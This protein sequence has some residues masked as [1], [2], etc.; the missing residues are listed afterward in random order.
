MKTDIMETEPN[1]LVLPIDKKNL[2]TSSY[3][4]TVDYLI[5][6]I[7]E[8]KIILE[9]P[10]ETDSLWKTEKASKLIESL[11]MNF[12]ISLHYLKEQEDDK[13]LIIDGK[14]RLFSIF[15]F[16][17]NQYKLTSLEILKEFE[18]MRFNDLPPQAKRLINLSVMHLVLI[19]RNSHPD[20]V[21][22]MAKRLKI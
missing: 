19:R 1:N 18:S 4:Y 6:L 15:N 17:Q 2:E 11:L 16:C 10:V 12:P 21:S 20:I 8:G 13:W 22:H 14:Q 3:D 5:N 7:E 9:M